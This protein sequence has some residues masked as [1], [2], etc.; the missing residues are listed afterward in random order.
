MISSMINWADSTGSTVVGSLTAT[1]AEWVENYTTGGV[2]YGKIKYTFSGSPDLSGVLPG[3]YL[4]VSSMAQTLNN[5]TFYIVAADNT[6]GTITIR[7]TS[8]TD[9][10]LDETGAT[11]S[12][13]V[14]DA[15]ALIQEPSAAKKAQGFIPGEMVPAQWLNWWMNLVGKW[16]DY[17]AKGGA[18][19]FRST[20]DAWRGVDRT[21][22]NAGG[23]IVN[24]AG[25]YRYD[26]DA[27]GTAG[28]GFLKPDIGPGRGR[29]ELAH[30][31]AVYSLLSN[32]MAEILPPVKSVLTF[33]AIEKGNTGSTTVTVP[34]ARVGDFVFVRPPATLETY[35]ILEKAEVTAKDT[36]TI[37]L[38]NWL[39]PL[40]VVTRSVNFGSMASG[41]ENTQT[42]TV[43]GA[44]VGDL[45][46]VNQASTLNAGVYIRQVYV[47]APNTVTL[48]ARNETGGTIDPAGANYVFA[49]YPIASITPA[50]A[51]WD[52][53]VVRPNTMPAV[54]VAGNRIFLQLLGGEFASGAALEAE[55]GLDDNATE[56]HLVCASTRRRAAL[57]RDS[58]AKA[59]IQASPTANAIMQYYEG[60]GY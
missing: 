1:A 9:A 7:Q 37:T 38:R 15:G 40:P 26:P 20:L 22:S 56:F 8:R 60:F 28:D 39:Y 11:G 51:V 16:I 27:T 10:T 45:V 35:L 42:V 48:V 57:L 18:L 21:G 47:S 19:V 29:I 53:L 46:L 32:D 4:T 17:F 58:A 12:A 23:E 2:K 36:V 34:G 25:L 49:V 30:P 5:G 3:H 14:I 33:G 59:V 13:S 24:S 52:V 31:D 41:A 50:A 6:A 43:T 54:T 55:L 44:S